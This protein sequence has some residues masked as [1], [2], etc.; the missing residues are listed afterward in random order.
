MYTPAR[1]NATAKYM[2]DKHTIR[3]VVT[4]AKADEYKAMAAAEGK[5]LNRFIID[6]V[7]EREKVNTMKVLK[8]GKDDE[9]MFDDL[10]IAKKY[11]MPTEDPKKDEYLGN[12]FE[13]YV[14]LYNQYK[15]E[16]EEAETL[17]ELASVLNKYTDIFDN[18]SEYFVKTIG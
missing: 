5:S 15:E 16:I 9:V 4:K 3:V 2:Q 14:K 13:E 7:E 17:E 6:C 12:D 8:N 10:E 1:A 18:G 11:Y